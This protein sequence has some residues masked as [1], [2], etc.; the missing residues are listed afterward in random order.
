MKKYFATAAALALFIALAG[1]AEN[2]KPY[3]DTESLSRPQSSVSSME[4]VST[5]MY[6]MT[7][8]LYGGVLV[9][10]SKAPEGFLLDE[11]AY[12]VEITENGKTYEVENEAGKG[13]VNR[14]QTGSL[15]IEKTSS[16]KK[17]EGFTFR[18]QGANGYDKTFVTDAKG[19]I[20]V[21]GLR[22]GDYTVS[23]VSDKASA[24]YV[25]SADKTVTILADKTT[26]AKMHNELRDTPKTGDDSTP[27]L[28]I[29]LMGA[30]AAGAAV[31]GILG[32]KNRRKEKS[33]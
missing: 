11:N 16:D 22:V 5:G 7:D 30:S 3:D 33:E 28:W 32:F 27:W 13:F 20:H 1:C 17:V 23:E 19:E 31:L 15:R 12:Y 25:L 9:K 6:E 21:E 24:N 8:I 4:E 10:E 26:V 2:N 18:V 29:A 14:A